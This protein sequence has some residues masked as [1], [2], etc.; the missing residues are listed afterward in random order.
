WNKW[1]TRNFR[2]SEMNMKVGIVGSGI[3]GRVLGARFIKHG[4]PVM[5]GTRDLAK[6]EPQS[7]VRET[8]GAEVA[9]ADLRWGRTPQV[10]D[11][12]KG[13]KRERAVID[14]LNPE[15]RRSMLLS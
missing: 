6:A 9:R 10:G 11:L 4:H 13:L 7:W 5:I 1:H 15:P 2:R 12:G 3:V 14:T 8:P